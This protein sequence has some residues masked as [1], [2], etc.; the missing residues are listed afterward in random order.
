MAG[1]KSGGH[2]L[3][4][5]VMKTMLS[6]LT[7]AIVMVS[8][9]PST[10]QTRIQQSPQMFARLSDKHKSLVE[11]GQITRGMEPDAVYL[12][13]GQPSNTMM[14]SHKGRESERWDYTGTRP[15]YTTNFF[16]TYGYGYGGYRGHRGYRYSGLG[17]GMGPEVS[18]V[19][20]HIASVW[21]VDRRVDS[22][23]RSR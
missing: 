23:E 1:C 14:G 21:F 19:P 12:A 18:Y 8:C 13:W 15:I 10:P 2:G 17:L 16:G 5:V 6:A 4:S 3:G 7:A 20:T 22:W 9:A 11:R